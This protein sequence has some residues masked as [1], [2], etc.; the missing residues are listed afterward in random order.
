MLFSIS[1]VDKNG[2]ARDLN[3]RKFMN[4]SVR[5]LDVV[6]ATGLTEKEVRQMIFYRASSNCNSVSMTSNHSG[7]FYAKIYFGL[8]LYL[9]MNNSKI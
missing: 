4:R 2:L 3:I 1:N 8:C 6:Y 9:V 7:N 5:S